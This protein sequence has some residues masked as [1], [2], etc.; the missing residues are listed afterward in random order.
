ML[1]V[2]L[3]RGAH[4]SETGIGLNVLSYRKSRDQLR[5]RRLV[6]LF[7]LEFSMPNTRGYGGTIRL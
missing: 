2:S 7:G 4:S 6:G 5:F 3:A 1:R